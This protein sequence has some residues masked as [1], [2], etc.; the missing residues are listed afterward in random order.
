MGDARL[1]GRAAR[2]A[3]AAL[4]GAFLALVILRVVLGVPLRWIDPATSSFMLRHEAA[5]LVDG[6]EAPGPRHAWV[7]WEAIAPA[8]PLAVVAA[9]DQR[10][11]RHS[12]FDLVEIGNAWEAFRS[13]GRIATR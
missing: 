7:D 2:R 11:P 5:S 10:F 4:L 1:G 12:G 6:S 3:R 9:E 13:G 8:V